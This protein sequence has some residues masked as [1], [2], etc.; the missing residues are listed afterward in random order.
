MTKELRDKLAALRAIAPKLNQATDEATAIVQ[1]V[2]RLLGEDLKL[3]IASE[4]Y[5][6]QRM[7]DGHENDDGDGAPV[8]DVSLAYGRVNGRFCLHVLEVTSR[9]GD[10]EEEG[11][12]VTIG[13]ERTPWSSCSR[14]LKLQSFT[15]LPKLLGRIADR[16]GELAKSASEA[17]KTVRDLL[18]AM[19]QKAPE[20]DPD[21]V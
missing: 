11:K 18:D 13:V 17:S 10:G 20:A 12:T 3:G 19:G 7:A 15:K 4:Y 14:E 1:S 8:V 5:F 16:A 9:K 6:H 2:E 21:G